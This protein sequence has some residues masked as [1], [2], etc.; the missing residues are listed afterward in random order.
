[1]P[2]LVEPTDLEPV[3]CT[4]KTTAMLLAVSEKTVI[5]LERKGKL[6]AYRFTD[7]PNEPVKNLLEQVRT[8]GKKRERAKAQQPRNRLSETA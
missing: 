8:L 1:M 2:K 7:S 3:Y 5:E 6:D 4:R